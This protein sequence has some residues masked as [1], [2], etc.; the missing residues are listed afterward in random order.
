MNLPTLFIVIS[1]L[2]LID[3]S[4]DRPGSMSMPEIIN[5]KFKANIR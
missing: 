2:M 4:I 1:M 5:H 3:A